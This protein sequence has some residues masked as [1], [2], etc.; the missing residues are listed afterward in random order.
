MNTKAILAICLGAALLFF[1]CVEDVKTGNEYSGRL[2]LK[3]TDAPFPYDLVSEANVTLFKVEARKVDDEAV[4]ENDMADNETLPF[5]TLMEQEISVNLLNLTN[6][7][8]QILADVEIPQGTYDLI[9]VYVKGVNV[10]LTDG[11]TFDLKVPSGEQTGIKVFLKP[12]IT[13]VGGLSTDLLLDFDV[14]RS[15]VAKGNLKKVDGIRGF[16][17]KPV[18]KASNLSTSGSLLGNVITIED[19]I[20]KALE[21]VQ[22]SVLAADTVNT[23]SFTDADGNY[24]IM[25]LETGSYK[26]IAE[27]EGYTSSDTLDIQITA[28]NK[29]I[30]DFILEKEVVEETGSD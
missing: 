9:R 26:A 1:S 2:I 5:I 6:G 24:M 10:V 4:E 27:F 23:S 20:E 17:F 25:G 12:G 13:V 16:N 18:I 8:T 11:R 15:F 3:L 21:G 30:Q 19:E 28:A 14:S 29:T 22:I 7:V